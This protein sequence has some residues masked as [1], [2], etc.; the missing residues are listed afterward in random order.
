VESGSR[1]VLTGFCHNCGIK[2][3]GPYC[4]ACGQKDVPLSVTLHDFAW[5]RTSL[6]L[7]GIVFAAAA[8]SAQAPAVREDANIYGRP[9]WVLEN[10]TIRVG[11]LRGGGHIAELRLISTNERLSINPMFLPAGNGYMGHL[12]AFPHY[13]PASADERAQGLG[14]HG[15]AGSVEW[16]QTRPPQIDAKSLTFRRRSTRSNAR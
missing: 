8:A 12:V 6:L 1:G 16:Q 10:G 3:S 4:A 5:M 11:L 2:V 15:E 13:G 9:G 7:L 14:G